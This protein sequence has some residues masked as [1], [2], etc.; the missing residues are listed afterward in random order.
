MFMKI[1]EIITELSRP[2]T[3]MDAAKLLHNAGYSE[4][5]QGSF[6]SIFARPDKPFILKLFKT[7]DEAYLQYLKLITTVSNQHFPVVKGKPMKITNTY[8]AVQLERLTPAAKN[9]DVTDLITL[10]GDY[11]SQYHDLANAEL[12]KSQDQRRSAHQYPRRDNQDT[13]T[14]IRQQM[15][16]FEQAYPDLANALRLIVDHVLRPLGATNDLGYS[17]CMIRASSRPTGSDNGGKTLVI[18]DPVAFGRGSH[19]LSALTPAKQLELPID[20]S[21]KRSIQKPIGNL[22]DRAAN[23]SVTDPS[24]NYDREPELTKLRMTPTHF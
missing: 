17:N 20:P 9:S 2:R 21:A 4:L 22:V 12:W 23:A 13:V 24:P 18:T 11:I 10:S 6:A 5:G 1:Y 15:A 16:R 19:D 7:S 14:L 8:Y 3:I